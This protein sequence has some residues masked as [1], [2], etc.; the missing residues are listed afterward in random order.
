MI[1]PIIVAVGKVLGILLMLLLPLISLAQEQ[2][3]NHPGLTP[4]IP[5]QIEWLALIADSVVH[6]KATIEEPFFISVIHEDHETLQIF[7]RYSSNVNREIMNLTIDSAREIIRMKAK[8]YGW[9]NWV[10][11]RERVEKFPPV[12]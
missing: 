2:K 10:K 9:Q 1:K 7:V 11:I 5:T 6:H 8:S 12:N 4:Y 3:E